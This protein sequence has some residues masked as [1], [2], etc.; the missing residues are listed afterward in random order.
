MD[1]LIDSV[2]WM[3]YGGTIIHHSLSLLLDPY[4]SALKSCI[5]LDKSAVRMI[6]LGQYLP[7]CC[8]IGVE[9]P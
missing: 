7:V 6:Y 8:G 1:A 3:Q 9:N 4:Y 5:I 2:R